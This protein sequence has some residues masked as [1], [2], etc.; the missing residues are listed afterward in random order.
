MPQAQRLTFT[1][2]V[3]S[4]TQRS[5]GV[6]IHLGTP[7]SSSDIMPITGP[8]VV[9]TDGRKLPGLGE[10]VMVTYSWGEPE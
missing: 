3:I 5:N 9:V 4:L 8:T 6:Y 10:D 1:W 2:Q 7:P